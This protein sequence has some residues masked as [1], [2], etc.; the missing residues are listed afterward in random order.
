MMITDEFCFPRNI[1]FIAFF[2][3]LLPAFAGVAI[4]VASVLCKRKTTAPIIVYNSEYELPESP[5]QS[6]IDEESDD[7]NVQET[8]N[9]EEYENEH[10]NGQDDCNTHDNL[11]NENEMEDDKSETISGIGGD[12]EYSQDQEE[13][14]TRTNTENE[15]IIGN[16]EEVAEEEFLM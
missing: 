8:G 14:K 16:G 10:V 13:Y 5:S 1:N 2:V 4:M 6:D 3:T 12:S 15:N 9:V 11:Q 7:V